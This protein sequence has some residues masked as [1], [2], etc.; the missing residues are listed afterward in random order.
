M[1]GPKF[2]LVFPNT[3][4]PCPTSPQPCSIDAGGGKGVQSACHKHP[5]SPSLNS[6]R[7]NI[8]KTVLPKFLLVTGY[9]GKKFTF[10]NTPHSQTQYMQHLLT[11]WSCF[12][13]GAQPQLVVI[14]LTWGAFTNHK[15]RTQPWTHIIRIWRLWSL[16]T[17]EVSR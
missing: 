9:S 8:S 3:Q 13:Q 14:N 4:P 15:A 6:W 7:W 2:P 12:Y 10:T 5:F 16:R 17:A 11:S 1:R